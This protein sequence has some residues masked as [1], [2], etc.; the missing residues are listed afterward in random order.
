MENEQEEQICIKVLS[1][2]ATGNHDRSVLLGSCFLVLVAWRCNFFLRSPP[3]SVIIIIP[4]TLLFFT[5]L[6]QACTCHERGCLPDHVLDPPQLRRLRG[7]AQ[8]AE[9][10]V[11]VAVA[12][13]VA[14]EV[15]VKAVATAEVAV[16]AEVAEIEVKAEVLKQKQQNSSESRSTKAE[17]AVATS[18]AAEEQSLKQ[19][20]LTCCSWSP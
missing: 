16:K 19:L 20:V 14:A 1:H 5:Q 7:A 12:V 15:A 8:K 13:V 11:V 9:I 18:K 6:R 3:H 4:R 10:A 17:I 2:Y